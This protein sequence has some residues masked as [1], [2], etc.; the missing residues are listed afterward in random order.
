MAACIKLVIILSLFACSFSFD[1][2]VHVPECDAACFG[3]E[4]QQIAISTCCEYLEY[5]SD[6]EC[7]GE[8][9]FCRPTVILADPF[10]KEF[11]RNLSEL[12]SWTISESN[13]TIF[14]FAS[15]ISYNSCNIPNPLARRCMLSS[16]I[17]WMSFFCP[18]SSF[19][20]SLDPLIFALV[21]GEPQRKQNTSSFLK[22]NLEPKTMNFSMLWRLFCLRIGPS[23]SAAT[24]VTRQFA[25]SSMSKASTATEA[26]RGKISRLSKRSKGPD[27]E[28][29]PEINA[30]VTISRNQAE[31]ERKLW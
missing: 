8:E 31:R 16:N 6:G 20:R 29:G 7:R 2:Y 23:M 24:T 28:D 12:W 27:G 18:S 19:C 3:Q 14:E 25:S 17:L 26:V 30:S 10:G 15:N 9:S 1:P 5:H 13:G 21:V 22:T 11:V 4:N